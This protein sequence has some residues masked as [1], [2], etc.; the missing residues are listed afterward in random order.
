MGITFLLAIF[1]LVLGASV[2][3]FLSVVIH[4]INKGKKGIIF[5]KSVCPKCR[6]KLK[7]IDLVP[8]FSYLF[9]KGKCRYC[10]KKISSEYL[11][12]ELLTALIFLAI[13]FKYPFL[14]EDFETG[15]AFAN[16]ELLIPFI[17]HIIYGIF[18]VG[19]FF[20]DL[21]HKEIPNL[22]LFPLI[23]VALL[24]SLVIG[25]PGSI[26]MMIAV[27]IALAFFG[28]QILI[29]GGK[30]LG[31]GDLYFGIGMALIFGWQLLIAALVISYTFGAIVS[32][33][34]LLSKKVTAKSKIPFAPFLIL[35]SLIT[36]FFGEEILTWYL[37]SLTI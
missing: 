6:K 11:S 16:N 37:T 15:T 18:F 33:F 17:F 31:E 32:V 25:I 8:I 34:L 27:G 4:R 21:K 9:L 7:T 5:G 29:S 23:A 13:Y 26:S 22:F 35:G 20:Y 10:K 30:W 24:G 2:G 1:I 28:G 36:M 14:I 19:I 3:S 12:L